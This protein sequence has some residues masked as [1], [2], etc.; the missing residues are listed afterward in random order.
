MSYIWDWLINIW[1]KI[2]DIYCN[3]II[4]ILKSLGLASANCP[5]WEKYGPCI[6]EI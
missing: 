6:K 4:G 5:L 1:Y 3:Y 2:L